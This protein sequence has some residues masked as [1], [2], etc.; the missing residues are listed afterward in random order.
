MERIGPG[1]LDGVKGL[2]SLGH[3]A[4]LKLDCDN[5]KGVPR[6]IG[7]EWLICPS[8]APSNAAKNQ[9]A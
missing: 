3:A 1:S 8:Q 9:K 2:G 6:N 5:S 7:N 4:Q